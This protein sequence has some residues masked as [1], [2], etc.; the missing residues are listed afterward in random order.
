MPIMN[1][2]DI[3]KTIP[4]TVASKRIKYLGINLTKDVK[5]PYLENY[6]ILKTGTEEDTNKLF[7]DLLL[8]V[9]LTG[10]R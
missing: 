8:T 1:K 5:D 6:K 4:F 2:R 7:V 3:K 10:M 9:I